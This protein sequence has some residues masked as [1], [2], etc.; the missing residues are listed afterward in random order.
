LWLADYRLACQLGG[1]DDD[2]LII[3]NLPLFLFD[4]A[5]AWLEH[6]PPAQISNWDDLVK[7]F[8][9]NFQGTYVRPGNSWDL[10]S[11]RQQS[12]ESLREYIRRFSKQRTELPNITDSDVIGAFLAGTTCR[13]L[14]SKL[15][16]KTPCGLG[17]RSSPDDKW[18]GGARQQYDF[19][20][21]KTEDLQRPQQVWQAMDKRTTLGGLESED[22]AEPG[23]G[24]HAVFPSL[25]GQ[26]HL[27]HGLGI[28]FPED[29]GV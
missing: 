10:R 25:W 9:G 29:K 17:R 14:V 11:C 15:G 27:T 20:G 21:T 5:R 12:G 19:A 8:A 16:P 4:A 18:A 28:R 24:L 7:A 22:D 1:A 23:H 3:R 2:N 26:G 13:D 6:L